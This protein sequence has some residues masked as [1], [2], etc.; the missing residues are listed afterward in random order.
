MPPGPD[1]YDI[2]IIV[3]GVLLVVLALWLA[4]GMR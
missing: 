1:Y 4:E 3:I 2:G